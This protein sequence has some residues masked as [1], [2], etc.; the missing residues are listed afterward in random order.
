ME[1]EGLI[2]ELTRRCNMACKHCLRGKQQNEDMPGKYVH[3]FFSRVDVIQGLTLSGGEPTIAPKIIQEVAEEIIRTGIE[4]QNFFIVTNGKKISDEFLT[5]VETIKKACSQNDKS[6]VE[7]SN[8]IYNK[9]LTDTNV[10]RLN[11]L[12]I[13]V[14]VKYESDD[15]FPYTILNE[16]FAKENGIGYRDFPLPS[17]RKKYIDFDRELLSRR[18]MLYLNT[19]GKVLY[20]CNWSYESQKD[21]QHIICD[22]KDF[23]F[24]TFLNFFVQYPRRTT[25]SGTALKAQETSS[26]N[27]MEVN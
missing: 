25:I 4:I 21:P 13:P 22:A 2:L 1:L 8:H 24:D 19:H 26:E 14:K 23:S 5:S 7:V 3:D 9:S 11:T 6:H 16:G 20:G 27:P 18:I 10:Q 17:Y 12:S 15:F